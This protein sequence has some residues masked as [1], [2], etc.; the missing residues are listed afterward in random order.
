LERK[1]KIG[2]IGCGRA[3]ELIY[4]PAFA[5]FSEILVTAVVDPRGERR[6]IISGKFKNCSEYSSVEPDFL[7]R[8]D[9]AVISTPPDTHVNLASELLKQN[10]FV[11]VE[12]PLAL[13]AAGIEELIQAEENTNAKLMMGFNHR[14]WIPAVHLRQSLQGNQE[15]YSAD[16]T[17]TGDYSRWNPVS[18]FSDPL[19]DLGPHVFDLIR[20][21]F[22][23]EIVSVKGESVE[24]KCF[25]VKVRTK[26][27][28][29]I[30]TYIA[31]SNRTEKS[32]KVFTR[33]ENYFLELA[34]ERILPEISSRRKFLDLNDRIRRKIFRQSSPVK[35][36]FERQIDIFLK[37]IKSN[38]IE[39]AGIKDG[40]AAVLA[41]NAVF[42]S[43][44][45]NGKEIFLNEIEK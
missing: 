34:S 18:F 27:N 20:F 42:A 28:L 41:V 21:I 26:G 45:N 3:A 8:I 2:L 16:I 4:S 17:F 5:K 22:S 29:I 10:K 35:R 38:N 15:I 40:T 32:I 33:Q 14:Y 24:N 1:I 25:K 37:L 23:E 12:K 7:N 13:T 9:A 31:H 6:K 11:L 44:Q 36:T 43:I 30:D 19:N 39:Y